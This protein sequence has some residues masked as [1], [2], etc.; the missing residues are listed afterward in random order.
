M[1]FG[2]SKVWLRRNE[3]DQGAKIENGIYGLSHPSFASVFNRTDNELR[4]Q[5]SR[6]Y[7]QNIK[8]I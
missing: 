3:I 7:F 6:L 1:L 8:S 2:L 5:S 4:R